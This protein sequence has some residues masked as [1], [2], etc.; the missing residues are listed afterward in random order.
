[1]TDSIVMSG[2]VIGVVATVAMDVWAQLLRAL[3]GVPAPNWAMVGRW[4]A[5][6]L[7]GRLVH[8]NI[9]AAAPVPGERALGWAFHYAVGVAYGVALAVIMGVGW[10]AAPTFIPAWIFAV[11]TIG[12]GWFVLHPGLGLGWAASKTPDPWRA[13]GLGLAAHTVFGVGLWLGA[14]L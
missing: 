11:L 2:V 10:L 4:V 13:R 5:H 3:V 9:G 12:F 7:R 6:M 14:L 8:D 1:M